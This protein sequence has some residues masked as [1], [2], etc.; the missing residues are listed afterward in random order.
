[1]EFSLDT[2]EAMKKE[3]EDTILK[4]D[5]F[6][7][8]DSIQDGVVPDINEDTELELAV[9]QLTAL[10]QFRNEL[11][12]RGTMSRS[13]ALEARNTIG[14]DSLI[15]L[16]HYSMEESQEGVE[17]TKKS[18]GTKVKEW[19]V[20]VWEKIKAYIERFK[21]WFNKKRG[22]GTKGSAENLSQKSKEASDEVNKGMSNLPQLTNKL[23]SGT[24]KSKDA[25]T[26]MMGKMKD[27]LKPK[28]EDG[29]SSNTLDVTPQGK[30]LAKYLS[31]LITSTNAAETAFKVGL[32][33]LTTERLS[34]IIASS[35]D[36]AITKKVSDGVNRV[37]SNGTFTEL[38]DVVNKFLDEYKTDDK[39]NYVMTELDN[40]GKGDEEQAKVQMEL[41]KLVQKCIKADAKTSSTLNIF[42]KILAELNKL[43]NDDVLDASNESLDTDGL[44]L[45]DPSFLGDEELTGGLDGTESVE[46]LTEDEVS[47]LTEEVDSSVEALEKIRGLKKSLESRKTIS[48]SFALESIQGLGPEYLLPAN[49]YTMHDSKT[50][51]DLTLESLA[52]KAQKTV[53]RIIDWIRKMFQK[54]KAQFK[55]L[56]A[57]LGFG[58]KEASEEEKPFSTDMTGQLNQLAVALVSYANAAKAVDAIVKKGVRA[59]TLEEVTTLNEAYKK[60]VEYDA[61]RSDPVFKKLEGAK[62]THQAITIRDEYLKSKLQ[63]VDEKQLLSNVAGLELEISKLVSQKDITDNPDEVRKLGM[64]TQL[65]TDL[66]V[67]N[68]RV[69]KLSMELMA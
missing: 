23:A 36:E 9:E 35:N 54:L 57:V 42:A 16:Y 24:K 59:I 67:S 53:K 39:M 48:R 30:A 17:E 6:F 46:E 7:N 69:I 51:Y 61:L 29:E 63:G 50:G 31:T 4:D 10:A 34:E 19:L 1:M 37:I 12:T 8:E 66:T 62:G 65:I 58:A 26:E 52:A 43:D 56:V 40:M 22:K 18:T 15:S 28:G 27:F 25:V 45:N 2:G 14:S 11:D 20:K 3:R 32:N 38:A 5:M 68:R 55:S 21:E 60:A 64:V 33:T 47:T 41:T 13:I 49:Y 44:S